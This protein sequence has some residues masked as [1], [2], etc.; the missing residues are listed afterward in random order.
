M[1]KFDKPIGK[2]IT[3]EEEVT[4]PVHHFDP[5][6]RKITT[7]EETKKEKVRVIYERTL[8]EFNVCKDFEHDFRVV[9]SHKYIIRCKKCPVNKHIMPGVEYIDKEGHVRRRFDDVMVA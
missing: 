5:A 6:T 2:W 7:E 4:R 8:P 9:D 1:P 3:E